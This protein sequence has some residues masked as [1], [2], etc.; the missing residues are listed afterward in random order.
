MAY[1]LTQI[2]SGGLHGWQWMCVTN[3]LL[4]QSPP[5]T[6]T[7][8]GILWKV[9]SAFVWSQSPISGCQNAV[10][11][12][13]WLS[14]DEKPLIAIRLERNKGVYDSEEKFSWSEIVRCLKDWKLY[15]QYAPLTPP[16]I[17]LPDTNSQSCE[18]LW[19]RHDPLCHQYVS[20]NLCLI[21]LRTIADLFQLRSCPRCLFKFWE[22]DSC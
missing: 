5:I 17:C 10:T 1:G 4:S 13:I 12:A 9:S 7:R 18:P 8:V 2:E 22:G 14:G 11:E 19:I 16:P 21:T 6:F 3:I 15:V 20:P